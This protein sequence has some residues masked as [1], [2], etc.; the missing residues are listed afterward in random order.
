MK[1]TI[2]LSLLLASALVQ[3]QT[4]QTW[5]TSSSKRLA[6]SASSAMQLGSG[7]SSSKITLI[8][9]TYYQSV[10]GFGWM[11]TEASAK[12]I[13]QMTSTNRT[14]LLNE[15]YSPTGTC[16]CTVVRIALGACD[17]SEY[18]Y[19]YADSK[20]ETLSNFS[21]DGPDKDYVI[22]V[23]KEILTINPKIYIMA[24]PWS[25]PKWMKTNNNW[26]GGKLSTSYYALYATYFLKYLQ[27]MDKEG[28]HVHAV[29]IQNEPENGGNNPSMTF[30][31]E[32]M[33]NFAENNLGPTLANNGYSD[34]KI[35]GFDHNCDN[36]SYPIHVAKS[37]YVSGTAFHLYGG[38]IDAM[39][40]VY[41]NSKKDVYFTEQYTG[42]G[43]NF[44][45][46]LSWHMQNVEIGSMNN[47]GRTCIEWNLVSNPNL[48]MHTSGGC[49]TCEGAL[50]IT[51][52]GSLTSRNLA[53]YIIAQC[54]RVV[55]RGA[56]RIALSGGDGLSKVAFVNP[57][58]SLGLVVY[59]GG[60]DKTVDVVYN[61][62]YATFTAC[63]GGAT[64]VLLSGTGAVCPAPDAEP[65]PPPTVKI[66]ITSAPAG[67]DSIYLIGSWGS[68]WKLSENIP[69]TK[70]PD[71]TWIGEVPETKF[72]Y[73]C[74]N[75]WQV[76]GKE[77]W[78]YEEAIDAK[79]TKLPQDRSADY[80]KSQTETI[81]VLYWKKQAT[82]SVDPDPGVKQ[83][84][85]IHITSAPAGTDSIY[86]VGNWSDGNWR[87]KDNIPCE[88]QEDGTWKGF[89][90]L[91]SK[92]EYK[93][94]NRWIVDGKETW[95]YEEAVDDKGTKRS[96]NR[97][98]D[99]SKSQTETIQVLYWRKQAVI[100][101]ID[102]VNENVNVN[103]KVM[104]DGKLYILR[105]GKY[106]SILGTNNQ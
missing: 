78:D 17:L 97:T 44:S 40:T 14:N 42:Q 80:S 13:M 104:K 84:V 54:S 81:Q 35:I 18:S 43:S 68:S 79:G 51:N 69:C 23:L 15:L 96:S 39:S 67:T 100:T 7:T 11:L 26:S 89:V 64:S 106:Y 49:N 25:A 71:G 50:T 72:T 92:F 3:A 73:K 75:R 86:L 83:G 66:H 27:A 4:F 10:E 93:C 9:T 47:Y 16:R 46:D 57:D 38:S 65:T 58:G 102:N 30:S 70:Q 48:D 36:T 12:L 76:G 88:R 28:I 62:K 22:P 94:W 2:F 59:N 8:P 95:D 55:Q 85:T 90:P 101:E 1:K 105:D 41:K 21:L 98:A 24:A 19:S 34:V 82:P 91:T 87:L 6:A 33:Y 31:K 77:T 99:Y 5:Q 37:Q 53:Y 45:G 29:S 74:W 20:D 60:S 56:R 103:R 63:G 52:N 61:G 32:E